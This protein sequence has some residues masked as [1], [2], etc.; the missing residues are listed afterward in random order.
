MKK[1]TLLLLLM[2]STAAFSF[3]QEN[4]PAFGIQFN[5]FVRTDIF[6]DTRELISF[7]EDH[8]MLYPDNALYDQNGK[9]LNEVGNFSM[10][11]ITSRLKGTITGPDAFGAK[12]SGLLEGEF[13]GMSDG[14]INGFR[15]RHALVKLKWVHTELMVGQ[16]WHPMFQ[17]DDYP[18]T[19]SFNTGSPFNPFNRSPQ[20]RL[21]R[22]FGKAELVGA[23][24]T[25]RDFSSFG[26]SPADPNKAVNSAIFQRTSGTPEVQLLARYAVDSL[27]NTI[28]GAGIGAKSLRPETFTKG[29][30]GK[31][32]A[33]A[34]KI[35]SMSAFAFAKI[36]AQPFTLRTAII[37]GQNLGNIVMLGGYAVKEI[38]DTLT[39]H[40]TFTPTASLSGWAD[41]NYSFG[42]IN[43]GIFTAYTTNLGA[44]DKVYNNIYFSRGKDIAYIYRVSPRLMF[45]SGKTD[46]NF[47]IDYTVAAYGTPDEKGIVKHSK[48]IANFRPV[49]VVMYSF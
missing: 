22:Q 14:D 48:E 39:N 47:E 30:D 8:L 13:F 11:C 29:T 27:R 43:V 32:Y 4:K 23:V 31:N 24:V 45:K 12:T 1:N 36:T 35:N 10:L 17:T 49:C 38:T 3:G 40:R 42:R 25:E 16:F 18:A 37:Y 41:L 46:I 44:K 28:F 6:Y 15:L 34:E 2:L 9:D 5:G 7:R 26:P 20:I 21:T 19:V 33:S